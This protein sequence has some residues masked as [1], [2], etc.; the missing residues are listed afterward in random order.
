MPEFQFFTVFLKNRNIVSKIKRS[1]VT[2]YAALIIFRY[3]DSAE[4][5][6]QT[7]NS[8]EEVALKFIRLDDKDALRKFLHKKLESLRLQVNFMGQNVP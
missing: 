3:L 4:M 5:Y 7:Q 8:F 1:K 2:D 6:A